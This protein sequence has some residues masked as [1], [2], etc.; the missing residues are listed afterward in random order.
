M[1]LGFSP[2]QLLVVWGPVKGWPV[3]RFTGVQSPNHPNHQDGL[4]DHLAVK[5]QLRKKAKE[6][7]GTE[8]CST[9]C[10]DPIAFSW[11]N[12]MGIESRPWR[13]EISRSMKVV[14]LSSCD[15]SCCLSSSFSPVC[16]CLRSHRSDRGKKVGVVRLFL[17]KKIG[18]TAK[19]GALYS[20]PASCCSEIG[21]MASGNALS[22]WSSGRTWTN[23]SQSKPGIYMVDPRPCKEIQR[24]P[25][26]F[27]AGIVPC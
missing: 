21:I 11:E 12:K 18:L 17:A 3:C 14:R 8:L 1:S 25:Q 23:E 9:P 4:P 19:T 27:L 2:K 10:R 15:S 26:L 22:K 7:S 24:R 6:P 5:S 16:S 13:S 20:V